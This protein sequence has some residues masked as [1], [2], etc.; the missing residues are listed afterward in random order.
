M[1]REHERLPIGTLLQFAIARDDID[2]AVVEASRAQAER[3]SGGD[4]EAVSQ[5]AGGVLD[6]LHGVAG[7]PGEDG[8]FAAVVFARVGIEQAEVPERS[9]IIR[10]S[11][12]AI[13]TQTAVLP[14]SRDISSV[15]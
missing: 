8:A 12:R 3:A 11:T 2:A 7:V 6:A 5:G 15:R 13:L 9:L 14:P 10:R 1:A 4:G